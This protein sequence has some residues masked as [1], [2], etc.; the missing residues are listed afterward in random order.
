MISSMRSPESSSS[1]GE[2]AERGLPEGRWREGRGVV[3]TGY[4]VS[5]WEEEEV[6]E[7]GDSDAGRI[8]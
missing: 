7:M 2:E 1:Q 5:V 3:F 4:R 6:Q 8:M